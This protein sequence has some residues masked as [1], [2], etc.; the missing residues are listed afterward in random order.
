MQPSVARP[1]SLADCCV[2]SFVFFSSFFVASGVVEQPYLWW[3]PLGRKSSLGIGRFLVIQMFQN[4]PDCRRVFDTGNNPNRAL[5][6]LTDFDIDV[7]YPFQPLG[8]GH[9]GMAFGRGFVIGLGGVF[10]V[11]VAV[12]VALTPA[13]RGDKC[14]V[15]AVG[16]EYSVKSCQVHSGFWYQGG[17]SRDKVQWLEDH[18]GGAV[19]ERCLQLVSHLAGRGH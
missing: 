18:M 6:L 11:A 17:Q 5:T 14:A 9:G 7:E 19:A 13:G 3:C 15:F 10:V 12:A 8:P 2:V 16:S 4:L 1:P